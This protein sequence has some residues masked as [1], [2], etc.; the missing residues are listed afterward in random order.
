MKIA[1]DASRAVNEK[2]GIGRYTLELIKKLIEI[3]KENQYLLLFSFMRE[4]A[5]KT[6]IIKSLKSA[7]VKTKVF[8][9]PGNLKEKVWGWQMPWFKHLL[10]DADI[11][12]APSFFEVNMGLN[13]PQVVTIYDLTTF[14]FPEHRGQEV[15]ERLNLRTRKACQKAVKIIAISESTKND[16]EKH[17]KI[18]QAK[19]KVVYPGKNELPE[20]VKNLPSTLKNGSYILAVGTIEPRK[21]LTGL[22]KAY[23]LLP[24]KLQEKYPLVIVGA[25]GWN[26]EETFNTFNHLKLEGKVKFLGFVPDSMLAKLY[27]EA[28]VFVY[29]S[30][31]E[32]F[33]FPVLEALSYGVPVVTSSVSSLPEVAGKAAVLVNQEDPKSISSGLQ[34]LLEHKQEADDLRKIAKIQADKFSWEKAAKETL[35]V[36]KEVLLK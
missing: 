27:K 14:L 13:I 29:P 25:E 35:K 2:A 31:Y 18:K 33:G 36:F 21:N 9:I 1:I 7:N 26:E 16:L 20:P 10:G 34:R 11:F 12:Y 22:F 6:K 32:G 30:L 8:K 28:A 3:D 17:L 15:S 24:I 23:A 5:Y 4:D 19:I